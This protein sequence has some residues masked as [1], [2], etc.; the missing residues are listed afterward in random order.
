LQ[1]QNGHHHCQQ[2][3]EQ[4]QQAQ[5]LGNTALFL[6]RRR[7]TQMRLQTRLHM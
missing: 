3:E 1:Q 7:W 4:Q 2:Q 6:A 5:T